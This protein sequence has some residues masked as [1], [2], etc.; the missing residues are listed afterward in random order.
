[1][2]EQSFRRNF[3]QHAFAVSSWMEAHDARGGIDPRTLGMEISLGDCAHRFYP[4]FAVQ[5]DGK[6]MFVQRLQAGVAGF[7]SWIPYPGKGWNES[8][9]KLAFKAFCRTHGL[10][11]PL[12]GG[13]GTVP[14]CDYLVKKVSG[15]LGQD[16]YGPF[17]VSERREIPQDY[18][19]E[20]FVRGRVVKAW[21][22]N[23]E[24]AVVEAVQM[25][26]VVGDGQRNVAE[27]AL[28]ALGPV[29]AASPLPAELLALQGV[30]LASV[31]DA[32]QQ[33]ELEYRYISPFNPSNLVDQNVRD[34]I[35][36]TGVEEQLVRAGR[37]CLKSVPQQF[38][39]NTAFTLDGVLDAEGRLWLL[40][41]NCN[42]QL[43]PAFYEP[44]LD[45][46][47]VRV[48]QEA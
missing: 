45:A 2:L 1:M 39:E 44:M 41:V 31:P 46:L 43:H 15:T 40:E 35:R 3:L 33:V 14:I 7:V 6:W 38:R 30:T 29:A 11:T 20:Q 4:Q 28:N 13:S 26:V 21:Y 23:G 36:G 5:R 12:F 22:W 48:P 37:L 27:L 34:A 42:P 32:G 25:P 9:D 24:L 47:F 10:R 19:W 16:L 17:P 8:R 18:F